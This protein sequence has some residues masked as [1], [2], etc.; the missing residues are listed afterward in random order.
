M[1]PVEERITRFVHSPAMAWTTGSVAVALIWLAWSAGG[2]VPDPVDKGLGVLSPNLWFKTPGISFLVNLTVTLGITGMMLL[3]NTRFNLL[4]DITRV[5]AGVFLLMQCALPAEICRFNGGSL[6]GIVALCCVTLLFSA[7]NKPYFTRYIFLVFCML[8]ASVMTQYGFIAF[9][10]VFM[11]GCGQMRVFNPRTFTAI[12]LGIVTPL[13]IAWTFGIVDISDLHAPDFSAFSSYLTNGGKLHF[14][15]T[16]AMTMIVG[17]TL[18]IINMIKVLN[19]N[20]RSRS[21]NGFISLLLFAT[22]ALTILDFTN[23]AFYVTLLNVCT[24]FQVGQFFVINMR[25]R[26]YITVLV[27]VALYLG[28]YVWGV[29]C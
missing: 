5:Y 14:F 19:Y 15:V 24:A 23:M 3:I 25:N 16:V 28:L 4:R 20:M 6:L 27:V 10:P 11:M 21:Y 12:L 8:A 22:G 18:C 29:R 1:R 2:G 7:Y 9:I 26:G 17:V 13:W